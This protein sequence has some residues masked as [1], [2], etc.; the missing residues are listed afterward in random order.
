AAQA[1]LHALRQLAPAFDDFVSKSAAA[2]ADG[3]FGFFVFAQSWQGQSCGRSAAHLEKI[4]PRETMGEK[5]FAGLHK[6]F[7]ESRFYLPVKSGG[8]EAKRK[9]A[10]KGVRLS[11][12]PRS[13]A[14]ATKEDR[15][16]R[17]EG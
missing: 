9:K 3:R 6:I 11:R 16:S 5:V 10:A 17:I 2:D 12:I 13:A 7:K 4:T 1:V 8:V 15:R 14:T